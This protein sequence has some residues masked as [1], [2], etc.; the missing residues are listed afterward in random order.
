[1]EKSAYVNYKSDIH[2]TGAGQ[3]VDIIEKNDKTIV[4]VEPLFNDKDR[5]NR[6]RENILIPLELKDVK[7]VDQTELN[8]RMRFR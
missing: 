8:K 1:M 5:R 2:G 6:E 7:V 4:L 3:I